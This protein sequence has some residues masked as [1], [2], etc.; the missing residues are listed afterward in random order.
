MSEEAFYTACLVLVFAVNTVPSHLTE[1]SGL[2]SFLIMIGPTSIIMYDVTVL[3]GVFT[4][5]LYNYYF[6]VSGLVSFLIGLL[7]LIFCLIEFQYGVIYLGIRYAT[8]VFAFT[9]S[10]ILGSLPTLL[11]YSSMNI[12]QRLIKTENN[13]TKQ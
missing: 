2:G 4:L 1:V 8:V 10:L 6:R 11:Y 12:R 7:F 13:S 3:L 9:A 5:I